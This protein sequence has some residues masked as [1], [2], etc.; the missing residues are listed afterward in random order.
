VMFKGRVLQDG[1]PQELFERPLHRFVG[2]FIGS[3]GMNFLPCRPSA[4]GVEVEGQHIPLLAAPLATALEARVL[5]IGVRPEAI[6]LVGGNRAGLTVQV[7]DIE[8]LGTRK[9]ATCRLGQHEIK[10][11]VPPEKPI[12]LDGCTLELNPAMT[13]LY[14]DGY[15]IS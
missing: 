6:C 4:G 11:S 8:D 1:T 13:R 3:P 12:P 7:R 9:I 2:Y 10:V 5:E 15:L 14:A